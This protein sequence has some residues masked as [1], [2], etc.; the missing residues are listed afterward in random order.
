MIKVDQEACIGCGLCASL[1][2]EIFAIDA[3][4][5]AEVINPDGDKNEGEEAAAACPAG[6][7]SVE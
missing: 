2:P 4:G 3:D 5:K 7:I 1:H 6:A